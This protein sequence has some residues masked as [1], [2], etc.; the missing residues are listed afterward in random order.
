LSYAIDVARASGLKGLARVREARVTALVRERVRL[1]EELGAADPRLQDIDRR[2]ATG[3]NLAARLRRE[4]DR[5]S[6]PR[7]AVDPDAWSVHGRVWTTDLKPAKDVTIALSDD[8]DTR[9]ADAGTIQTDQSG[10]F[11]LVWKVAPPTRGARSA[12]APRATAVRIEVSDRKGQRLHRDVRTLVPQPGTVVY[13]EL[14]LPSGPEP[15]PRPEPDQRQKEQAGR[16][17]ARSKK[18]VGS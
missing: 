13:R 11:K 15:G 1:E 2:I 12:E 9:I 3:R 8:R 16:R 17:S 10:Y 4:A 5:A 6:T 18:S 7:L 14:F